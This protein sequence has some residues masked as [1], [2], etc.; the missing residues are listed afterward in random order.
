MGRWRRLALDGRRLALQGATGE[1]LGGLEAPG[2]ERLNK[3][4]NPARAVTFRSQLWWETDGEELGALGK[5]GLCAL[6]GSAAEADK[7]F[8]HHWQS[9][10]H[11]AMAVCQPQLRKSQ[12]SL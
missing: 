2:T 12:A 6:Q 7:P 4:Q 1:K 5:G 8:A 10:Q 3:Q 9:L 11:R